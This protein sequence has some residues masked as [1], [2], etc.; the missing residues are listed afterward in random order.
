M[1]ITKLTKLAHS[2]DTNS[3]LSLGKY[4]LNNENDFNNAIKWFTA[5]AEKNSTACMHMLASTI[6]EKTIMLRKHTDS[7]NYFYNISMLD[8]ALYWENKAIENGD[9]SKDTYNNVC[10]EIGISYYFLSID[11]KTGSDHAAIYLEISISYLKPLYG[12]LFSTESAFYLGCAL[13]DYS[14]LGKGTPKDTE[15]SFRILKNC[16]D[17]YSDELPT[18]A[19]VAYCVGMMY[20]EGRG[21]HKSSNKALHYFQLAHNAGYDCTEILNHFKKNLFGGYNFI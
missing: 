9:E 18:I 6:V 21:C 4:Y 20:A 14:L 8:N 13:H 16:V 12:I 1:N 17:E 19:N 5:G 3:I 11:P 10:S 2:G 7:P 15:L